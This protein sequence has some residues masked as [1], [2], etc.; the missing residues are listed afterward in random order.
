MTAA[1]D[2]T[3]E[4]VS[5]LVRAFYGKA[6]LDPLL[7]PVFE[8]AVED[9]DHH[10]GQLDAFWSSVV[11]ATGRYYGRPMPAHM[12]LP[13]TPEMF[14]RWLELWSETAGEV[15]PFEQ[16]EVFR[17]KARNIGRSLS[18]ALFFRPDQP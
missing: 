9:W 11:L 8:Q 7:G 5:R 12:Q 13:L 17:T 6:R 2:I 18:L 1:D 4:G 16:A 3:E 14:T 15:F 10:F